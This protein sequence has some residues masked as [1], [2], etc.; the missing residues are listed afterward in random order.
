MTSINE[1]PDK[2]GRIGGTLMC[3]GTIIGFAKKNIGI[4]NYEKI[5]ELASKGNSEN[6]DLAL[7]DIM[8]GMMNVKIVLFHLWGKFPNMHKLEEKIF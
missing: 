7:N 1:N 8:G 4:D 5:L 6:V 3:G 2:Y